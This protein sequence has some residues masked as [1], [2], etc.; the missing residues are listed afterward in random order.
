MGSLLPEDEARRLPLDEIFV[1]VDAQMPVLAERVMYFEDPFFKN[2]HAAQ[3]E[4]E[5][6]IASDD[7]V[8]R[9]QDALSDLATGRRDRGKLTAC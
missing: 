7:D 2:I 4:L 9:V 6:E 8:A 1:V 5:V 3:G